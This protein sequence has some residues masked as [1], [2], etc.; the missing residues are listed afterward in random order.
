MK[1]PELYTPEFA[2][3]VSALLATAVSTPRE[4]ADV[5]FEYSAH[6]DIFRVR[7]YTNGWVAN[8]DCDFEMQVFPGVDSDMLAALKR[9]RA[10]LAE[11]LANA[12]G[13]EPRSLAKKRAAEMRK[14]A[15]EI[16]ADADAL[17]PE[18]EKEI[19]RDEPDYNAPKPLTP[20]ENYFQNDEHQVR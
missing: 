2:A 18:V 7:A 15:A 13:Q 6:C 19:E 8:S 4:V 9:M 14:R 17:A 10:K 1:N 5:F 16:L 20:S 3:E 11:Y 12:A